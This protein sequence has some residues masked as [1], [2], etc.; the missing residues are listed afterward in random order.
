MVLTAAFIATNT[1]DIS[2]SSIDSYSSGESACSTLHVDRLAIQGQ[3]TAHQPFRAYNATMNAPQAYVISNTGGTQQPMGPAYAANMHHADIAV[4][5]LGVQRSSTTIQPSLS[6][7][8]QRDSVSPPSAIL[9][10]APIDASAPV[11][12]NLPFSASPMHPPYRLEYTFSPATP[13]Y[14]AN[15]LGVQYENSSY[16]SPSSEQGTPYSQSTGNSYTGEAEQSNNWSDQTSP[17]RQ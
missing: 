15:N 8:S 9:W 12:S 5:G 11:S 7:M 1:P 17:K 4:S 14:P 10:G 13:Y 6:R 16:P 2:R 3:P